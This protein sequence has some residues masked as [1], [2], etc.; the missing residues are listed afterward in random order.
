[1]CSPR[2]R[3]PTEGKGGT[4]RA[5]YRRETVVSLRVGVP[6]RPSSREAAMA[7]ETGLW[8]GPAWGKRPAEWGGPVGGPASTVPAGRESTPNVKKLF[9]ED[10]RGHGGRATE[11]ISILYS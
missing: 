8:R 9:S 4:I 11:R 10:E 5:K 2:Q 7:C 3:S 1:M 6:A